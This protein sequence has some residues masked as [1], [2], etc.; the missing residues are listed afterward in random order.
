MPEVFVLTEKDKELLQQIITA[1]KNEVLGQINR[2]NFTGQEN[3]HQAPEVY[4]AL[5]PEDG[6]P[7]VDPG[8]DLMSLSDDSPGA[9]ECAIYSINLDGD[10]NLSF[11]PVSTLTKKVY[12]LSSTEVPG[13]TW[14]PVARDKFGRWL[15]LAGGGGGGSLRVEEEGGAIFV[16]NVTRAILSPHYAYALTSPAPGHAM[17]Q[18]LLRFEDDLGVGQDHVTV[19]IF[20]P[21]YAWTI[22]PG[23]ADTGEVQIERPLDLL[24]FGDLEA[25]HVWEI[26]LYPSP[27]HWVTSSPGPGQI[28]IDRALYLHRV[29]DS[30]VGQS[31]YNIEFLPGDPY[32]TWEVENDGEGNAIVRR[33]LWVYWGE[34]LVTS[35]TWLLLF[36]PSYSWQVFGADGAVQIT[37]RLD[38]YSFSDLH[39]TNVSDIFLYP[40]ILHWTVTEPGAGMVTIDRVLTVRELG[41]SFVGMNIY[42][43]VFTPAAD[44]VVTNDG[45]GV[46]TVEYVGGGSG[47]PLAV[48]LDGLL[49]SAAVTDIDFKPSERHWRI[50]EINPGYIIV[51]R[52]LVVRIFGESSVGQS[53][54]EI[55]LQPG[56]PNGSWTLE[57]DTEGRVDITRN[58]NF[59][60]S[61]GIPIPDVWDAM[62]FPEEAWLVDGDDGQA[63]IRRLF[64]V[65]EGGGLVSTNTWKQV[66]DATDFNLAAAGLGAH[67]VA[68]SGF[69]G[70]EDIV[71]HV[72]CD[73]SGL[74]VTFKEFCWTHGLLKTVDG[75]GGVGSGTTGYQSEQLL[76]GVH[77]FVQGIIEAVSRA[78]IPAALM[79]W[80]I[81]K[82]ASQSILAMQAFS[83]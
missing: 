27:F 3:D 6:I 35:D 8:E 45:L 54:Q 46:V 82:D 4:V 29:G 24:N 76:V 5:A 14:L 43:I 13:S 39:Q 1:V 47:S 18:R 55:V 25:E 80:G 74:I 57:N 50:E 42:D 75:S 12:N 71:T 38:L 49:I 28:T 83:W 63:T 30:F 79:T 53:I 19:A 69:D 81:G 70:C 68:T 64:D 32:Q 33:N 22:T 40:S 7:A 34:S 44:W 59:Y 37:R 66:F 20:A 60:H 51:D 26:D 61:G 2:P 77:A 58:L 17:W 48:Y 36:A 9:A 23:A 65:Y 10:G 67:T 78:Q 16:N 41:Q 52:L 62:F 15:S 56:L 72:E 11:L 73:A 21:A 31:I